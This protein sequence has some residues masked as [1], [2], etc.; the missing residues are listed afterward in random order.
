MN[1]YGLKKPQLESELI[2]YVNSYFINL[3]KWQKVNKIVNI[4]ITIE[5]PYFINEYIKEDIH[6]IFGIDFY[7]VYLRKKYTNKY[8]YTYHSNDKYKQHKLYIQEII[9]NNNENIIKADK[10]AI[11]EN[12]LPE[13]NMFFIKQEFEVIGI[14]ITHST[15]ERFSDMDI[16]IFNIIVNSYSLALTNFN[17]NNKIKVGSLHKFNLIDNMAREFKPMLDNVMEYVGIINVHKLLPGHRKKSYVGYVEKNIMYLKHLITNMLDLSQEDFKSTKVEIREF[18]SMEII[19]RTI[20]IFEN[21]LQQRN[22]T[23]VTSLVAEQITA[24]VDKFSHIIFALINNIIKLSSNKDI[25]Y[26]T[27]FVD[28]LNFTLEFKNKLKKVLETEF[29]NNNDIYYFNNQSADLS[30]IKKIVK[31][32]NGNIKF[33]LDQKTNTIILQMTL[34]IVKNIF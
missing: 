7:V 12:I 14:I 15:K 34:P 19:F 5:N 18:N 28:T 17:F 23:L 21:L 29:I 4:M 10:D 31:Q 22:I 9:V 20:N 30:V 33:L 16:N 24:D 27:T 13:Y 1:I 11:S 25:I 6:W 3:Q 2:K 32:H 26:I 8:K